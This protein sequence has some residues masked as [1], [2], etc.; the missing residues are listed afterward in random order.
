[1]NASLGTKSPAADT[2]QP[3]FFPPVTLSTAVG[4]LAA[5]MTPCERD[6]LERVLSDVK[7][8]IAQ[9]RMLSRGEIAFPARLGL[10]LRLWA[11]RLR[12]KW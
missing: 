8:L 12:A 4:Q 10:W 11:L 9:T 1:M 7:A 5:G 3:L 6:G 2:R